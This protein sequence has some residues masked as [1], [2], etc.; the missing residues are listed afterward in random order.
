M[1]LILL[2]CITDLQVGVFKS[3]VQ[4]IDVFGEKSPPTE[5]WY[6]FFLPLNGF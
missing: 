6:L 3:K 2:E 4:V 1:I 5:Y